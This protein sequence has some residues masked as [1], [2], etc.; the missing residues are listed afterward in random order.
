MCQGAPALGR[1]AMPGYPLWEQTRSFPFKTFETLQFKISPNVGVFH[2]S[3]AALSKPVAN[4]RSSLLRRR[5]AA[6]RLSALLI[7]CFS[8]ARSWG[9]LD[10]GISE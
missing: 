8:S 4:P 5:E 10:P 9:G 6:L 2:V 7:T 1:A 3:R